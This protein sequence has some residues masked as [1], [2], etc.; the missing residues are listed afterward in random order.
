MTTSPEPTEEPP[1][2][3]DPAL[4]PEP[5]TPAAP[6]GGTATVDVVTTYYGWNTTSAA[7]EVGAYAATVESDG[8]CTLTLTGPGGTVTAQGSALADASSTS[9]G[10][11]SVPGT[12][13]SS[14]SWQAVVGYSSPRSRGTSA[15]VTVEVP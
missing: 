9:C 13:L 4:D 8:V 5:S 2:A 12:Q 14:G 3:E 1:A 15:A 11:L 6:G 7:V 10:E